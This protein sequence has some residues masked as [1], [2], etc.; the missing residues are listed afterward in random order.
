MDTRY[1]LA[2]VTREEAA[3]HVDMASRSLDYV[4]SVLTEYLEAGRPA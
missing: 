2:E 3:L 1:I 4:R